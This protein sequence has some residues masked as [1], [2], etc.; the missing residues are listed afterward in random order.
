MKFSHVEQASI[1]YGE[2]RDGYWT[3]ESFLNSSSICDQ[4]YK[5]VWIFDHSSCLGT[6]EDDALLLSRMNAMVVNRLCCATQFGKASLPK[7]A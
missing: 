2:N 5:V 3:S 7:R 1:E 4:G 6:Y